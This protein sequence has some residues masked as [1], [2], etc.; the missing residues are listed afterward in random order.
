[1]V[2]RER[3]LNYGHTLMTFPRPS[4][5]ARVSHNAHNTHYTQDNALH[6]PSYQNIKAFLLVIKQ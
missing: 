5:D 4:Q 6:L 2:N 3:I 1:M